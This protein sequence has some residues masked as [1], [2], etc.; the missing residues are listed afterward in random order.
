MKMWNSFDKHIIGSKASFPGFTLFTLAIFS[1]VS[2][3]ISKKQI[4]IKTSLS[5]QNLFFVLLLLSGAVFS[6]GPRINFNG[7]YASIPSP[8]YIFLKFVPLLESVRAP[9]RWSFL[10]YLGIVYFALLTIRKIQKKN[11]ASLIIILISIIFLL[12][13]IPLNIK[14]HGE[15]YTNSGY[16][17]LSALCKDNKLVLLEV[18]ITHFDGNGGIINGLNRVTKYELSSLTHGCYL[19]NGYSG[20]DL[21][22]LLAFKDEFYT[23]LSKNN[24]QLLINFLKAENINLIKINKD[25]LSETAF[26]DYSQIFPELYKSSKIKQLDSDIFL[27]Q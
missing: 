9:S 24:S 15:E 21:P 14:T 13:Y 20:Y 25:Q 6:W 16:Q 19:K 22:E 10:F 5:H 7:N 11:N 4:D 8:Y 3:K 17:S 26:S 27:I 1:L 23:V 18:P 12:E 2:I